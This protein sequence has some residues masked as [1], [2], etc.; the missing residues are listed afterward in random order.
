MID[1]R[2]ESP[3]G[4]GRAV[5]LDHGEPLRVPPGIGVKSTHWMLLASGWRWECGVFGARVGSLVHSLENQRLTHGTKR[6]PIALT[7]VLNSTPSIE[8]MTMPAYMR[9]AWKSSQAC[10]VT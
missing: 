8:M 6:R 5:R 2:R 9:S 1:L 4:D 10:H 7:M 3:E